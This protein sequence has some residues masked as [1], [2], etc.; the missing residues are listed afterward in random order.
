MIST[1]ATK[2]AAV[3]PSTPAVTRTAQLRFGNHTHQCLIKT[4]SLKQLV[5]VC[6]VEE[7]LPALFEAV[8]VDL[9]QHAESHSDIARIN[10]VVRGLKANDSGIHCQFVSV[11]IDIV[12]QDPSKLSYLSRMIASGTVQQGYV[13][14]A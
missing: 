2:R 10:A 4:L 3:K 8:V 14:G 1:P 9:E 13:P 6:K 7:G 12:D 11:T 5:L